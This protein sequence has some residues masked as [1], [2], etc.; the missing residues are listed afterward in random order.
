[1]TFAAA[2]LYDSTEQGSYNR[3][4][5]GSFITNI[6]EGISD[7]DEA[8][9]ILIST[10]PDNNI[11]DPR[12]EKEVMSTEAWKNRP[13]VKN[14]NVLKVPYLMSTTYA[15]AIEALDA[16]DQQLDGLDLD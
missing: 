9:A 6:P 16:L 10:N 12:F 5:S 11:R 8:D 1:M 2:P 4:Y 14:G 7:L 15:G 3:E 13:A